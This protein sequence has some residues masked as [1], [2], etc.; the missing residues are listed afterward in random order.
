MKMIKKDREFVDRL[1]KTAKVS[2]KPFFD[3]VFKELAQVLK[4][5]GYKVSIEYSGGGLA[6]MVIRRE[7]GTQTPIFWDWDVSGSSK[8]RVRANGWFGADEFTTDNRKALE[9]KLVDW[10]G[11]GLLVV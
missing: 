7:F 3:D 5:L 10:M 8:V 1:V 6:G 9:D 11:R 4:T 2:K